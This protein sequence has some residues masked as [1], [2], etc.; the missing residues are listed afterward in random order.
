MLKLK[1]K[2]LTPE[3]LQEIR[4]KDFFDMILPGTVKFM[5]DHYI[6][7]DSYR[8]V[9]ANSRY[10][11]L[12]LHSVFSK[13]TIEF[14]MFNSTL[15]AGEVK[16]YIQ[17]CLLIIGCLR[18]NA[19]LYLSCKELLLGYDIF[20]KDDPDSSEWI[21]Y[22]GLADS[23]SL[24]ETDMLKTLDCIAAERGLSYTES[25]F[26]RTDG[27]TVKKSKVLA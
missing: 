9:W 22:D 14:R 17:L 23:V 18:L 4:T 11:G 5:S 7:G 10:H 26:N 24:K 16:S 27:K 6:V 15:H 2:E 1:T 13:G 19:V 25:C 3:Q 8:C 20:V 21:Y 12:N